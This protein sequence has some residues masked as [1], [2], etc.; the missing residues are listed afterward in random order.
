MVSIMEYPIE[1][2]NEP[3]NP[4]RVWAQLIAKQVPDR[5]PNICEVDWRETQFISEDSE[6]KYLCNAYTYNQH[7][8]FQAPRDFSEHCA[9]NRHR[10]ISSAME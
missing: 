3:C 1:L 4:A 10:A 7:T 5:T 2:T 9:S 8:A 6:R